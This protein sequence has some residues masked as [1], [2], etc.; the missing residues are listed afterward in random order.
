MDATIAT[1]LT[2][3][4]TLLARLALYGQQGDA[5]LDLLSFC[6]QITELLH[7]YLPHPT[8]ALVTTTEGQSQ[9]LAGWGLPLAAGL[10]FTN[11]LAQPEDSGTLL[12]LPL[13]N[14]GQT[15]SDNLIL[16]P[17]NGDAL[18]GMDRT[19]YDALAAQ[20]GLLLH[21][22]RMVQD[23]QQHERELFVLFENSQAAAS[24]AQ[25]APTLNRAA[26]NIVLALKADTC[27]IYLLVPNEPQRLHL[28]AVATDQT[29]TH[30]ES[31]DDLTV[32][33][34]AA[35]VQTLGRADYA[36]FEAITAN[37]VSA[38]IQRMGCVIGLVLPLRFHDHVL[39]VLAI[40]CV[41]AGRTLT[42]SERNLLQVLVHQVA[43]AI[44]SR[45][46]RASE[47]RH[48]TELDAL[49]D[50]SQ[51]L[52]TN[53]S[54]D[55][56]LEM[57]LRSVHQ[58]I[59][60]SGA[61][62]ALYDTHVQQ[63]LLA[64]Q[65]GVTGQRGEECLGLCRWLG[66]HRRSL[67]VSDLSRPS[68]SG[69]AILPETD[70]VL[71]NG[72]KP[73]S[74]LGIPL[75]IG[76]ELIGTLELVSDQPRFFSLEHE[77]LLTILAGQVAQ[78]FAGLQRYEQ[79][80]EFLRA[81]IEQ[82]RALQRITSQ[83][84]IT[85]AQEDI[86]SFVLNEA[87]RATSATHGIIALR[88]GATQQ[89][90]LTETPEVLVK[91][92]FPDTDELA[93][94]IVD[95][96]L[97]HPRDTTPLLLDIAA[98]EESH[99]EQI[100]Y[101]VVEV[102]GYTK[103][104]RAQMLGRSITQ[105]NT[106]AYAALAQ[107]EP[108]M[109][110]TLSDAER[111][112]TG[113]P[114]AASAL[115]APIF[116]EAGVV[117]VIVLLSPVE[118]AFD[119]EA[120]VFI[121]ALADQTALAIGNTQRYA[122]LEQVSKLLQRRA[123]ILHDVLEIGQ[124]LRAD[125]SLEN[126]LEQVGYS[127]IESADFR[128]VVFYL[129]DAR[130]PKRLRASAGAGIPLN[131][132]DR[133]AQATLPDVFA[134]RFLDPRFRIGNGRSFFVPAEYTAELFNGFDP[135]A[136]SYFSF[137]AQRS[138]GEWQRDDR[139]FIPLYST[140]G[141]L[142]GLMMVVDPQDRQR[143]NQ[144]TAETLEIFADQAAIAIENYHLLRDAQAQAEQMTALF[145]V[146]A[147]ATST[148]DLETLLERVYQEI[149]AY[150]GTPSFFY[151]ASYLPET[152]ETRFEIF[153]KQGEVLPHMNHRV[154]PKVGLTGVIIDHGQ[155]LLLRDMPE[156]EKS[157][158]AQSVS[159]DQP[160]RSWLGVPLRSQNRV[161][162]VLSV[163]D[164]Q[165]NAFS[166][167]DQRFLTALANQLAIAMEK[168]GL[169]R[170]REQRIA[171]LD[172][173]NR[174]G[175][176]TSSTLDLHEMTEQVFTCLNG[177]LSMDAF[178]IYVY[179]AEHNTI[180][181]SLEVDEGQKAVDASLGT[182]STGSLT[183]R[184]IQT[185]QPLLFRDLG[186]ER[187]EDASLNP[188]HFGNTQRNSAAWLGVPLLIGEHAVIGVIAIQ[189]YT[190]DRYGTREQSF[191]TTVANQLAL[192][193]QNGLLLEQ[194][195]EQV[196]R[197]DLLNRISSTAASVL[198]SERIYQS[199]IDAM[200]QITG[201]D[202]A[203]MILY[204]RK[205]ALGTVVAEHTTTVMRDAI[206]ISLVNNPVIDWLD[207]EMSPLVSFDV[208]H[209]ERHAASHHIFK[210]L[211]VRSNALIPLIIGNEVVGSIGLD[212]IGRQ[213][214]FDPQSLELCQTIANQTSTTM[215]NARL[216]SEAQTSA[217]ALQ[218]KVGELS[219][220]L[221][222]A[223]ILSSLLKPTEVLDKMMDLVRRQLNVSTV[224]LWTIQSD[225]ILI[226]AAMDG[227]PQE[228]GSNM[229]VPVGQGFTG[230]VAKTGSP[231]I[232]DDVEI[233]GGSF[234]PDF[235]RRNRLVSFMGVPVVYREEI[236]GVL[237][238]MTNDPRQ[239]TQDEM[240]LLVGLAD[241][242]ATALENARLFQQRER[243]I[244][245]LSVINTLSTTINATLDLTAMLQKLHHGIGEVLDISTSMIAL[246]N[247]TSNTLA[248][249]IAYDQGEPLVMAPEQLRTGPNAWA[250]RNRQPLLINSEQQAFDLRIDLTSGR[251]G[252]HD[253]SEQSFLV[254]PIIFGDRVLGVINIQSY[255]ANAFQESDLR[256][257]TT[258][259]NQA[260]VAI[261]NAN[262]F[263]E[264]RQNATETTTLY[265]V[266]SRLAGTLDPDETQRLVSRAAIDLMGA[267]AAAVM[268]LDVRGRVGQQTLSDRNGVRKELRI[269]IRERGLTARILKSDRPVIVTDLLEQ[270]D[271]NPDALA[272]GVRSVL[273][274]AIGPAEERLGV[275]WVG[276]TRPQEW[277]EHYISLLSILASQAGQALKAAQ[278][279]QMEQSRRRMA[280][281]LRDVA[282]SF[283]STLALTEIQTLILDQLAR[284][285][286]YDSATVMLRDTGRAYLQVTEA[287]GLRTNGVPSEGIILDSSII[288]QQLATERRPVRF[289]RAEGG[290]W[291]IAGGT[292]LSDRSPAATLYTQCTAWI[293]APMLV[294][295]ELVGILMVGSR[296]AG[297]Y[298]AEAA[299]V[300]FALASQASQAI[301][302][303]RLFDQISKFAAD[304]EDRVNERTS[305]L[306]EA[307]SQVQQEKDRLEAVHTITLELTAL[308]DLEEIITR[309]LAMVSINMGVAHG[310]IMLRDQQSGEL[311]CRAVLYNE[312]DV[313]RVNIPIRFSE[314]DGLAG[315]V[316]R[317][318]ERVCIPDVN[319]DPRWIREPGRADSVRS[320]A[321][322]P[323][324]TSDTT[325]GV[326]IL[327]N[328]K[329]DYFTDSQ[330]RLL[331]T[332]ANEVSIAINNAQLYSY[333]N[334]MAA[335][336]ADNIEVQ[337]EE[338]SKSRAILESVT[339]GV[340]MLDQES[341]I[342]LFNLAAEHVLNIPAD[343]V[344]NKRTET[345]LSYG[346]PESVAR[347]RAELVYRGLTN[348]LKQAQQSQ[349]IYSLSLDLPDPTQII[350]VNLTPVVG[351]QGQRY[352][353][354]AVLRD[355]TREIESDRA[356]RRFISDVSHELRTPLTAIKG[357]IDVL[358]ITSSKT[359]NEEQIAYLNI[360]KTNANRL[361]SLIDD[362]L[363]ISR[364]M[365]G[366]IQLNLSLVD[367]STVIKDVMQS[368]RME[369]E[370]K[371]M[372][373]TCDIADQ[374][375][376]A[377]ADQKRLTQVFFNL[378]SNA[379]K[380]T[381]E[382]GK[383]AV[384]SFL[385]P[386][387]MLQ[388]EVEDNG[389]GMSPEDVKKLFRPFYRADNPLREVAGGTGLGLSIAKSF[390][391][392]HGGE[393]WVTSEKGKGSTF[394]F[395]LPLEGPQENTELKGNDE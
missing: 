345:L 26:E 67:R 352:G 172:V 244:S 309:A 284:V 328:D 210:A 335:D 272:I 27:L 370:N 286:H 78:S 296:T 380:Y 266:A 138:A 123:S 229:Q 242:A 84:A 169:F 277:S 109:L 227:I 191:L 393:M 178:F 221:D 310:S 362:I 102:T 146:G 152:N 195:R 231:L 9:V 120:T 176:F 338:A 394:S 285:V 11:G 149:V 156:A 388:V 12:R 115:A 131:E 270:S 45:Q 347:H 188:I 237:S 39:G 97:R 144:R 6:G 369:T 158:I 182:P 139:I 133:I 64:S 295:N 234:Y 184:I 374:L 71:M 368:L 206:K 33:D 76:D 111:A 217:K 222:A 159:V 15:T 292:L 371:R 208:L 107:G 384:R 128:T 1:P 305:A 80:D 202:Q 381:Y 8:G 268:R 353:D 245:E 77:Q 205:A 151:I 118:R 280:D 203:R 59:G 5:D 336:L 298:D 363:D 17:A 46:Q 278:L 312:G 259:S 174:I 38:V 249:P 57:T 354:V 180:V 226:P 319:T 279:F 44:V 318:Q 329:L 251:V 49:Q 332:I 13:R 215:L 198:E 20:L 267:D 113:C 390:V 389:V 91:L 62:L 256:F 51:R 262:L 337:R 218:V 213:A 201:V 258:V 356:K 75:V 25:L 125:R 95:A 341:N 293:A 327:S 40:G 219:T 321:A 187:T 316:I 364:D 153:L 42:S 247:E 69:G 41:H 63:F 287:R 47:Q 122:Q 324:M 194:T 248:Y 21:T 14:K 386:S 124:A 193:V 387:N 224:A 311:V 392:K 333:I 355:I 60:F 155:A 100:N 93:R 4:W 235:Q 86:L 163:Q 166:E 52:S 269:R 313:R 320:A 378:Y 322:V 359:L 66:R 179:N 220:L 168:A 204:D 35:F 130:Q 379:I 214:Y 150:L 282:Q 232:V 22:H 271:P 3:G 342:T 212:F 134:L 121:R 74:Y 281:T 127:V 110:D 290:A 147:A 375:P 18:A 196:R 136:L 253:Y 29:H 391:E 85:L 306:E 90:L 257:L 165:P 297:A 255:E 288:L 382:G 141:Q 275:L 104:E 186:R 175:H 200:V 223:R 82:L 88:R 112:A 36:Q 61:R 189:S 330:M 376:L 16:V 72:F 103:T 243:Q 261:N 197:L 246:Y 260:A 199:V 263:T 385:T 10:P 331:E 68:A 350:A 273:G 167:R 161:I 192:G 50:I 177:F 126:V 209:D 23:Q 291:R 116:Y 304:L 360:V 148:V 307:K 114:T 145:Q 171:E 108:Q 106:T 383:I 357:Y 349:G 154:M 395:V 323:L 265:E 344:L 185:R 294:D 299:E 70:L 230:H 181:M 367:I 98:N 58:L 142:L 7:A 346:H 317:N 236:I 34:A 132:L 99:A 325:L 365:D 300:T 170:E 308:L 53:L 326:L 264:V 54:L 2:Q 135:T 87:I 160:V 216:F 241:Q 28:A 348:G 119:H 129:N 137:D 31:L 314:G 250:I 373:V 56:T 339:E 303:A 334:E 289:E 190:P 254:T 94:P 24:T 81:R 372:S 173:I 117:G 343:T 252:D 162:G 73:K 274:M 233:Q 211:D 207:R 32:M 283:T 315:W 43:S 361:K 301:Q 351:L 92:Y 37:P 55:E 366:R 239:F 140:E 96:S 157:L 89:R 143:P 105:A 30:A 225:G 240:L 302:N 340:I 19:F 377:R 83:L 101:Y 228:V 276:S 65:Q 183:E 358:L 238:V 79:T 48:T 164:F